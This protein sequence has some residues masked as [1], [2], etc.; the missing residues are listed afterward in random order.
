MSH[1]RVHPP[2]LE[3]LAAD[4]ERQGRV[5]LNAAL[6]EARDIEER[7]Q[8]I[9]S[10]SASASPSVTATS[11]AQQ[12][13][14]SAHS[15]APEYDQKAENWARGA[16]AG[17]ITPKAPPE[18]PQPASQPLFNDE[19]Q[20][21]IPRAVQRD[22]AFALT[23]TLPSPSSML[24]CLLPLLLLPTLSSAYSF[25]FG[26]TPEECE[27]LTISLTGSGNPPYSVLIIPFGPS[28]L[29]N[30]TEVRTIF[31]QSFSGTS[32]SFQLK[33]PQNSQFVAVVSDS[34]GFG[35]GGTSGVVTVLSGGGSSCYSTD[36]S[37]APLWVYSLVPNSLTQCANTRIWW[38]PAANV[39]GTPF[40]QGIIPGGQSFSVPVPANNLS[41]VPE[42]GI[43][44]N[45]T[46]S[47]RAGTTV[48]LLGGDNHGPGT[49]GSSTYIVNFGDNSCLNDQ[50]PS[51]T[52]GSPAGGSY[53]TSTSGA[54]IGSSSSGHHTDV[55]AIV[56]GVIGGVVGAVAL[57]LVIV[58][59]VRRRRFH[60]TQKQRPM[61]LLHEND[62]SNDNL[63]QFYRPEP[64]VVPGPSA[65]ST[66]VNTGPEVRAATDTR[67]SLDQRNSHYSALTAEQAQ[68]LRASTPD[69]SAST[70]T[71]LRKSPAPPSFRPVNIVQHEDAGPRADMEEPEPE[72]IELPP[73]YTN[74]RPTAPPSPPPPPPASTGEVLSS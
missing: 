69:Q 12:Q 51:S 70:S 23:L 25:N 26:S 31:Q 22:S 46:P 20:A 55:G 33:Y 62:G 74:I 39:S 41:Q 8:I 52:P 63:P 34:S 60:E 11:A 21:W 43:G 61:D 53:P 35:S 38:D 67:P 56:G 54:G 28:P 6:I 32:T 29:P 16:G 24:A 40:F 59:F 9:A 45:W 58:F 42:Q 50:S 65:S 66:A 10:A 68:S 36:S 2:S 1:T 14:Q 47:V 27:G 73:A 4:L 13:V 18:Q 15:A 7:L 44:F 71:Y 30:N 64:F 3:E 37:V 48:I 5:R 72:T 19:P 17:P 57:A 49:G